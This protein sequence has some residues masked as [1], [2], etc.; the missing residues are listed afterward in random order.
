MIKLEKYKK[1]NKYVV[2]RD[3]LKIWGSGKTLK[4]ALRDFEK[5]LNN[6]LETYKANK[7]QLDKE[8]K[9]YLKR[10]LAEKLIFRWI[11]MAKKKKCPGSKIRSKGKGRGL[12][13]GKGK[14]PI[15]IPI[16]YDKKRK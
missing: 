12:G 1:N 10:L 7:E 8:A 4:E 5:T 16:G 2:Y 9:L 6:V 15:G 14:G 3:E 11:K 13:R